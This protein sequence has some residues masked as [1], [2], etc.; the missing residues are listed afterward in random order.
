[1]PIE[2]RRARTPVGGAC[3]PG[4]GITA[5]RGLFGF[6]PL[7]GA[8]GD[9]KLDGDL[10]HALAA[11][12]QGLPDCRLGSGVE[13]R[14]AQRLAIGAGTG[15]TRVDALP[16]DGA[17]GRAPRRFNAPLAGPRAQDRPRVGL[18]WRRLRS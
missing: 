13:P 17:L 15:E 3:R 16:D 4:D 12:F 7:H 14:A 8:G 6:D 5:L 11:L 1:M 18:Y 2:W 10:P 9:A